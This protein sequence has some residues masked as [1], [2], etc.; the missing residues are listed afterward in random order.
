MCILKVHCYLVTYVLLGVIP[1]KVGC[2]LLLSGAPSPHCHAHKPCNAHSKCCVA[3]ISAIECCIECSMNIYNLLSILVY[4]RLNI[5]IILIAFPIPFWHRLYNS[6]IF[7]LAPQNCTDGDLRLVGGPSER[8]GRVE[9]CYKGFW[10]S[11]SDTQWDNEDAAV[12]CS[13]Q[14]FE[15]SGMYN[16]CVFMVL[17]ASHWD[18]RAA[19]AVVLSL[20]PKLLCREEKRES[21]T[22]CLHNLVWHWA[23]WGKFHPKV[24]NR[25]ST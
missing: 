3:N 4:T 18:V 1:Q 6:L 8:E 25:R 10:G 20:V 16:G 24:H 17:R 21:G 5:F 22:H 14:G 2:F 7:T 11:I 23:C 9:M 15:P 19:S 12:T 13:Q